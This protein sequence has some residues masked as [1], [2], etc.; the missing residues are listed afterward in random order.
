MVFEEAKVYCRVHT[1]SYCY[2]Y[3][4]CMPLQIHLELRETCAHAGF[5]FSSIILGL[6][7]FY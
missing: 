6:F 4:S 5:F 7:V 1:V 3:Y 2:L